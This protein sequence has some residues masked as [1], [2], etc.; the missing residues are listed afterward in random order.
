[1]PYNYIIISL[2]FINSLI[3]SMES[4]TISNDET[5]PIDMVG[6]HFAQTKIS[7]FGLMQS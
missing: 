2:L 6:S 1:L 7:L 4:L 3:K 5:L